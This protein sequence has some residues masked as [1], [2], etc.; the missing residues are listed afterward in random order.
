MCAASCLEG[1]STGFEHRA[2]FYRSTDELVD[3]VVPFVRGGLACGEPVLVALPPDRLAAVEQALGSDASH[4]ELV[5]MYRLGR[6][7]ARIIG[8]WRRFIEEHRDAGQVRAVGEPGWPG[9]REAELSEVALHE[10]L[11][12]LAWDGGAGWRLLCPYDA[13]G[14][15]AYVLDEALRS[16]PLTH[17]VSS[18]QVGYAGHQHARER[19]AAPLTAPPPQA[20][21]LPFGGDDLAGLRS[22]V[23]TLA[24]HAGIAGDALDDL[25]LATHEV[26]TNSIAHG[27]G[28]GELRA[29][30]E[31][32]AF[33]VQVS[34]A[35]VIA[36]PMV[37]RDHVSDLDEGGRGLWLA[38]QLCDLVQVRSSVDGTVVRLFA[39]L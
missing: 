25:V 18:D 4:V 11:M 35:G 2:V 17:G 7:P 19:F 37:G 32:G 20:D 23:A 21:L 13:S 29:W 22:S 31:P 10:A 30:G 38:N 1:A 24:R 9:R 3:S 16:H 5:D 36:D 6:N 12:N 33:V 15:P 34:D 14:L 27:G 39:W 26:A 28:A 8:E